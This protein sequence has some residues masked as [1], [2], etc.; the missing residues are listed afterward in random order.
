MLKLAESAKLFASYFLWRRAGLTL[1]GRTLIAGLDSA[2]PNNRMIAGMFLVRGGVRAVPLVR[3]ALECGRGLPLI[4][5]VAGDLGSPELIPFIERYTRS[6]DVQ[7]ARQAGQT[8]EWLRCVD[9]PRGS[10]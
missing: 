4:L 1:A 7:I 6:D 2:D 10:L 5:N 9:S 3:D 8:L